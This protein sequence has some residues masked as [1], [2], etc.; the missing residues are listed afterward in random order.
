MELYRYLYCLLNK[1]TPLKHYDCG[2]LCMGA[3]CEEN[4]EGEGMYLF[5]GEEKIFPP[6]G[7]WYWIDSTDFSY[8]DKNAKILICKGRCSR[9]MRPLSCRIFPLIP[10]RTKSGL[11]L[12]LDPRGYGMCPFV[13]ANSIKL[14]S[15]TFYRKVL[16]AMKLV[17]KTREGRLFI[18]KLS[19][20]VDEILELRGEK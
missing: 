13:Q 17:D 9:K 4:E 11:E 20:T 5:P 19:E 10:H 8:G 12:L 18:N 7:S 2:M 15:D 16:Y 6:R 14:L 3:C 1:E